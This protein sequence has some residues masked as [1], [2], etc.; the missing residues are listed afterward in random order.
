MEISEKWSDFLPSAEPTDVNSR[1]IK[2]HVDTCVY[3]L[4][5]MTYNRPSEEPIAIV[6]SGCRFPGDVTSTSKLWE[7]LEAPYDLSRE[8]PKNRFNIAG[9]Y[10]PDGE[11]HGTTNSPKAYWIEQD[12]RLFDAPFFNITPKEAEAIDPQHKMLLEVVHEAM[13]SAGIPI[14]RFSGKKVSCFI[15]SMTADFDGLTQKDVETSSQYAATGT[16]RAIISNRISYF[17]NWKGASMTIDTAC[18]SS[19]VALH[20]AILGLRNG[21]AEAACVGGANVMLSPENYIAEASLHMLSPSGK[22]RMW[23]INADGYARGEGVAAVILKTLS[24]AL[25]DGDNIE[26]IV[27]AS[28]VNSNGRGQGITMPSSELQAALINDTFRGSGLDPTNPLDMP[29]YFVSSTVDFLRLL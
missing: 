25:A 28:G 24:R 3:L 23:D 29:Q 5:T 4:F 18:S 17:F 26:G 9:F 14:K 13:D 2:I 21:E 6:G 8:V 10:H 19:L 27:R 22:S 1:R 7:L 15:G 11:Y 16:S 12:H 20:Q